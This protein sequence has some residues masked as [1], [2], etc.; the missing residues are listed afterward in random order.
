MKDF[1]TPKTWLITLLIIVLAVSLGAILAFYFSGSDIKQAMAG[2]NANLSGWSW[3]NNY[4]WISFNSTNCS[5]VP[6]PAGCPAS[7]ADY[8]VNIDSG[9]W[10]SGY[11]WSANSGWIQ[12][13]PSGPYPSCSGCPTKSVQG[14]YDPVQ[15]VYNITGWAKIV[16]LGDEGWLRME[17]TI[18]NQNGEMI[19][20]AWNAN[21]DNKGIGWLSFSS[22]NCDP[23]GNGLSNG[24]ASA[25]N[26]PPAGTAMSAYGVKLSS[27]I[28]AP[29]I[30]EVVPLSGYECS[31]L[32]LSWT[33][34]GFFQPD[35]FRVYR[36]TATFSPGGGIKI[37]SD[38]APTAAVF[39]DF[40]LSYGTTYYYRV[41][42]YKGAQENYSEIA[43]GKTLSVCATSGADGQGECPDI[44]HLSWDKA[45]GTV[46]YY[47]VERCNNSEKDCADLA[48]F[49]KITTGGCFQ[50][51]SCPTT[52]CACDDT[53]PANDASDKFQYRVAAYNIP[54]DEQ[55]S[56]SAPSRNITPCPALPI[57]Q[58]VKPR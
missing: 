40:P 27:V 17:D 43:T 58:E 6:T 44:V 56:W 55:S 33:Y 3:N 19:G 5:V 35:G 14:E 45:V 26:C 32:R 23:D 52:R 1:F 34:S 54:L 24:A 53:V 39:S 10:F 12:F 16:A 29:Q 22:K 21:N 36:S 31:G 9:G 46:S 50:S 41:S 38:L 28:G 20:W 49:K 15:K 4:G 18:I 8:G 37:G 30:S 25:A 57:W 11:G 48:N 13:N 7:G 42:A 47:L 51:N 2:A